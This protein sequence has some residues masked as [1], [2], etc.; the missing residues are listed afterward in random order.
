S[1]RILVS[2]AL[3]QIFGNN[4]SIN[5]G[6][7]NRVYARRKVGD[8]TQ[9]EQ[10]LA[11]DIFQ[12]YYSKAGASTVDPQYSSTNIPGQAST[13]P[14]N[15]SAV[16]ANLRVTPSAATDTAVHLEFDGRYKT[17]RTISATSGY[18]WAS[19]VQSSV[20]WSR[21]FFIPQLGGFNQPDQLD[22]SVS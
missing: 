5:Y 7:S 6:L 22:D 11:L 13:P 4:T 15:F 19:R 3:D 12:T 16:M 21:K 2:D 1:D 14:S 17:I 18:N 8:T 9:A 10:I 20:T